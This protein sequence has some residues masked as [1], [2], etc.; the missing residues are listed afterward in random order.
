MQLMHSAE[1]VLG[2]QRRAAQ[3]PALSSMTHHEEQGINVNT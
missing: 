3:S 1:S 2:A